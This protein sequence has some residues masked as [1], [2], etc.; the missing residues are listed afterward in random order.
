MLDAAVVVTV[1]TVGVVKVTTDPKVVPTA[2]EAI[3]QT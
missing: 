3:A 2:F 1:G